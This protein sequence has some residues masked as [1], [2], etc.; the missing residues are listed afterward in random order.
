MKEEFDFGEALKRLREGK[1]VE[2]NGWNGKGMWLMLVNY[3][4]P[5]RNDH[6]VEGMKMLPFIAM[7][8]VQG[9]LVPWL[10]SQTDLLANDWSE[11][12]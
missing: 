6:L 3:W 4:L 9:D 1:R 12:D 8:T 10:A 2:R 5:S 11:A 7:R